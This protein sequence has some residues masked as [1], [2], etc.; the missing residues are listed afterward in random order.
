MNIFFCQM[1]KTS[2]EACEAESGGSVHW[3][4]VVSWKVCVDMR[5]CGIES[6]LCSVTFLSFSSVIY[7]LYQGKRRIAFPH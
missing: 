3:V 2:V 7:M 4:F 6:A 1:L 5:E